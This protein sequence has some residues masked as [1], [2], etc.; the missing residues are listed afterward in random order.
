MFGFSMSRP[1][2]AFSKVSIGGVVIFS[3]PPLTTVKIESA[4]RDDYDQPVHVCQAAGK[5][6]VWG[7]RL[8]TWETS[9]GEKVEC[10]W[11]FVQNNDDISLV[12]GK[13]TCP[14]FASELLSMTNVFCDGG[15]LGT[16]GEVRL[17]DTNPATTDVVRPAGNHQVSFIDLPPGTYTI[18]EAGVTA[19]VAWTYWGHCFSTDPAD[20]IPDPTFPLVKSTSFII[21]L[22]QVGDTVHCDSTNVLEKSSAAPAVPTATIKVRTAVCDNQGWDPYLS[23]PSS[24]ADYQAECTS[25]D[26]GFEFTMSQIGGTVQTKS[27]AGGEITFT[28]AGTGYHALLVQTLGT[29]YAWPMVFCADSLTPIVAPSPSITD[30]ESFFPEA[31]AGIT[32]TFF[33]VL[34]TAD[35]NLAIRGFTCPAAYDIDNP[36]GWGGMA[37][38]SDACGSSPGLHGT[39][40][41]TDSDPATAD[42]S[43]SSD[44]PPA[45]FLDLAPG[46]YSLTLTPK[47]VIASSFLFSCHAVPSDSGPTFTLTPIGKGPTVSVPLTQPGKTVFCNWYVVLRPITGSGGLSFPLPLLGAVAATAADRRNRRTSLAY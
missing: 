10:T 37:N 19:G 15:S 7:Q 46:A 43:V 36:L 38:P 27:T 22:S 30:R 16:F 31:G 47:E 26:P 14:W 3:A 24:L 40:T 32:C 2:L 18:T 23:R 28:V 1:D 39:I 41:L 35:V 12:L 33:N 20:G 44:G 34:Q 17:S 13:L 9:P 42:Q 6:D 8:L 5:Y 29:G 21:T 11:F 25:P 4:E 45:V